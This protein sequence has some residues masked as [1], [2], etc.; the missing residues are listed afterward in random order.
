MNSCTCQQ[1]ARYVCECVLRRGWPTLARPQSLTRQTRRKTGT[2]QGLAGAMKPP[3]PERSF[4]ISQTHVL[5]IYQR[6]YPNTICQADMLK[7]WPFL[8]SKNSSCKQTGISF[9]C[10]AAIKVTYRGRQS[11]GEYEEE[12]LFFL[13]EECDERF[14]TYYV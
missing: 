5:K 7:Y 1:M 13:K 10:K 11:R 12:L 14:F 3:G 6:N 9:L 2:E 8:H 4:L